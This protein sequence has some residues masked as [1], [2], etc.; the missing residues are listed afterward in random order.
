MEFYYSDEKKRNSSIELLRL[1]CILMIIVLHSIGFN[2]SCTGAFGA[3]LGVI[4]NCSVTTFVL[5][6][7]YYGIKR[8]FRKIFR[9]RNVASFYILGAVVIELLMGRS[10]SFGNVF[11]GVSPVVSE[12]ALLQ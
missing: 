7:G 9:L 1:L 5:I 6:S 3:V 10:N 12:K 11:S 2:H 4:G 8:D